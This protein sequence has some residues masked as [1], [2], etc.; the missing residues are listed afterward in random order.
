MM[1][2][3]YAPVIVVTFL[4]VAVIGYWLLLSRLAM[5][6]S[7]RAIGQNEEIL[8]LTK[9]LVELQEQSNALLNELVAANRGP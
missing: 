9:R 3:E 4:F 8:E 1:T 7:A 5:E 6:R 2:V